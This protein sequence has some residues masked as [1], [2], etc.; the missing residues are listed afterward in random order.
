MAESLEELVED[1]TDD[2][3]TQRIVQLRCELYSQCEISEILG[4]SEGSI[5]SRLY[6]LRTQRRG[7][8]ASKKG[9]Q[10]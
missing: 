5:E 2:E 3:L 6:R 4:I 10:Q 8:R 1:L 7:R 9:E